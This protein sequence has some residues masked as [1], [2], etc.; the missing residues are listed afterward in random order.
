MT[1]IT[2][3]TKP[4]CKQ[5]DM[6]KDVLKQKALEHETVDIFEDPLTLDRL[7]ALGIM[8]APAVLVTQD[9]DLGVPQIVDSWGGFRP[10]KIDEWAAKD[11]A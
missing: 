11:A 2:V 3:Y 6:T 7:K 10:D 9:D 4:S 1:Q 8:S 5:C